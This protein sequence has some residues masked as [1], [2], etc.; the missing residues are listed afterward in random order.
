LASIPQRWII[1]ASS[2]PP[3]PESDGGA[4]TSSGDDIT[5]GPALR[6]SEARYRA[7]VESVTHAAIIVLDARGDVAS[8]TPVAE[9]L[10][11]YPEVEI[12]GQHVR[13]LFSPE[14]QTRGVPEQE[15]QR[16]RVGGRMDSNGW[17]V[18]KDGTR[19]WA[20]VRITPIR[21][22]GAVNGF[23]T[24]LS[25][26]DHSPAALGRPPA[27]TSLPNAS[28]VWDE[29][30]GMATHEL[31]TPLNAILGWAQLLDT[32]GLLP[33]AALQRRGLHAIARNTQRHVQLVNDLLDVARLSVGQLRLQLGPAHLPP[34]IDAAIAA[35]RRAA[36]EKPLELRVTLDQEAHT[37]TADKAR[38][39]QMLWHLLSNAIKFTPPGG[40]IDLDTH[41][42]AGGTAILVR[43]TG[44]GIAPAALPF[45]FDRFWQADSSLARQH[46]GLGLGLAIVR[47]LAALHGGRVEAANDTSG[48]GAILSLQLPDAA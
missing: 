32:P 17:R 37:V 15:L 31:R 46:G 39:Q 14:D 8:W 3:T 19:F 29:I 27:A 26:R 33:D 7:L 35:V 20:A 10:L 9:H 4:P 25:D 2:P 5:A 6:A 1:V 28:P 22:D 44:P 18:R 45:I 16:A 21:S 11:G 30:L 36:H 24:L 48:R 40:R 12:V 42:S 47:D 38:L 13:V 41:R 43:D 34:V 23:V